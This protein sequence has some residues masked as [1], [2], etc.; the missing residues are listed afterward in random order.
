MKS[1]APDEATA[2]QWAEMAYSLAN[3]G[4]KPAAEAIEAVRMGMPPELTMNPDLVSST[5]PD[6]L[7]KQGEIWARD[8]AV[9]W[10]QD[11]PDGY[12]RWIARHSEVVARPTEAH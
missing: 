7:R 4:K 1:G 5:R 6:M 12:R 10:A 11:N 2:Q 3:Q 9:S 8:D